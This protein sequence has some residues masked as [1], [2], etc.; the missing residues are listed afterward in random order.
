MEPQDIV[1][2]VHSSTV[3]VKNW[4]DGT[5]K[6]SDEVIANL[7]AAIN[8]LYNTLGIL[9]PLPVL[10]VPSTILP[11]IATTL[12]PKVLA[13]LLGIGEALSLAK[14]HLSIWKD[15]RLTNKKEVGIIDGTAV[16]GWLRDD[17]KLL[18]RL[19]G[20]VL[21]S[22]DTVPKIRPEFPGTGFGDIIRNETVKEFW[23]DEIGEEVKFLKYSGQ[24][25]VLIGFVGCLCAEEHVLCCP[26]KMDE[27]RYR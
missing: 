19:V 1:Q 18:M 4:L 22:L 23:R 8:L 25:P 2:A 7:S 20:L 13:S 24:L 9:C 26:P 16:K 6:K 17:E 3:T 27:R 5:D 21:R 15:T 14:D 12:K 11:V 10:P